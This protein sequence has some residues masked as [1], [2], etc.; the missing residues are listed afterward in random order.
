MGRNRGEGA[1]M[2]NG[3]ILASEFGVGGLIGNS[4][5]THRGPTRRH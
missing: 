3:T 5:G 2:I 1:I 4:P